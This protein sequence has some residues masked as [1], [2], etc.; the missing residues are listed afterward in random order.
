MIKIG[1]IIFIAFI[2]SWC[3]GWEQVPK[4]IIDPQDKPRQEVLELTDE[5]IRIIESLIQE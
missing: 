2:L 4:N 3:I 1:S 5:E